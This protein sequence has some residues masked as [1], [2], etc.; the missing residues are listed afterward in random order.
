MPI[1]ICLHI[2]SKCIFE[3]YISLLLM[4]IVL[5]NISSLHYYPKGLMKNIYSYWKLF[6]NNPIYFKHGLTN[7]SN[8]AL[9]YYRLPLNMLL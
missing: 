6:R 9:T 4:I 5:Q 3:Q 1:I 2:H 8:N 7:S